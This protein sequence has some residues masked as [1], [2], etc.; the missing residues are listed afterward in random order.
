MSRRELLNACE[1]LGIRTDQVARGK[2]GSKDNNWLRMDIV[3]RCYGPGLSWHWKSA[4]EADAT[5]ARAARVC[6]GELGYARQI[7]QHCLKSGN[8]DLAEYKRLCTLKRRRPDEEAKLLR[9]VRQWFDMTHIAQELYVMEAAM[10][11]RQ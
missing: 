11:A 7:S 2:R 5:C 6:R 9:S 8:D 4:A 10:K 3:E 1:K